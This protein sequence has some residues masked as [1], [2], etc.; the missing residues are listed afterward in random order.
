MSPLGTWD[1]CRGPEEHP[2][3]VCVWQEAAGASLPGLLS[4][5]VVALPTSECSRLVEGQRLRAL[6]TWG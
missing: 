3:A 1:G 5:M 6:L 2:E 4:Q